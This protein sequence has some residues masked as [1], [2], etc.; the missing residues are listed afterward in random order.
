MA[1]C[2]WIKLVIPQKISEFRPALQTTGPPPLPCCKNKNWPA[3]SIPRPAFSSKAGCSDARPARRR[4]AGRAS[5]Q[6][7][8]D[9]KA[10]R[11]I[12]RAGQFLF[13]QH[14]RGGGPVV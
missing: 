11:G 4:Q 12:D 13:L 10:G 6:P 7:A 1:V 8:F 2:G 14:G 9:E 5:L 3:R